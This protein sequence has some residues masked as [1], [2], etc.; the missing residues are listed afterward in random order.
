MIT[1]PVTPSDKPTEESF[2]L[3]QIWDDSQLSTLDGCLVWNFTSITFTRSYDGQI[4]KR[5]LLLGYVNVVFL[6]LQKIPHKAT[7]EHHHILPLKTITFCWPKKNKFNHQFESPRL[8]ITMIIY[9]Y[10]YILYMYTSWVN[11]ITIHSLQIVWQFLEVGG[12]PHQSTWKRS[13]DWSRKRPKIYVL[14]TQTHRIH[15]TGTV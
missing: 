1:V 6:K 5:I 13:T 12:T 10:V 8:G 3:P 14:P 4:V 7:K 2:D 9:I 11:H 15:G